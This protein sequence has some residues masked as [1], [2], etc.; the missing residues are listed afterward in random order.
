MV[1]MLMLVFGSLYAQGVPRMVAQELLDFGGVKFDPD[2]DNI[3]DFTYRTWIAERPEYI[4]YCPGPIG[5]VTKEYTP[6]GR[7]VLGIQ[8]ANF[9]SLGAPK[10][11][12]N[13]ETVVIEATQVSTGRMAHTSFV[14]EGK[15]TI[16]RYE[17]YG[18]A[19][20][21]K[22]PPV[23]LFDSKDDAIE[24]TDANLVDGYPQ[25]GL[26]RADDWKRYGYWQA[27]FST[28]GVID[29]LR[30]KSRVRSFYD[31]DEE[32]ITG[33]RGYRV[34]YSI[35]NG[36]NWVQGVDGNFLLNSTN[37]VNIDFEL[38]KEC[39]NFDKVLVKWENY[40]SLLGDGWGEIGDV[41]V[42]GIKTEDQKPE[43][44]MTYDGTNYDIDYNGVQLGFNPVAGQPET[45]IIVDYST[46]PTT[47][48]VQMFPNP[49]ALGAYIIFEFEDPGVLAAGGEITLQFPN[50]P[51]QIWYRLDAAWAPIPWSLVVGPASP[52]YTY[53]I[54]LT[55]LFGRENR[56]GGTIEFA[57]DNGLGTLPVELA[58]FTA[59]VTANMFVELQW[60][61]ETETNMLGYNVYR[62][63]VN[64]INEAVQVTPS[65]IPA[66]NVSE[67][68]KYNFV[69]EDVEAGFT[70]YYWLQ[71]VDLDLTSSFHGPVAITVEEGAELPEPTF[72]TE[73]RRNFPNPFNPET[74]IQF[75]LR[76]DVDK[77]ELKVYNVLG[78]VVRT[79]AAGPHAK[80]D[81][82][83]VW[84]GKTDS[85]KSAT[86]GIYFYQ[87]NT[88]N[89]SKIHKMMLLK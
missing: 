38:P 46:D 4:L 30:V 59:N 89:Y 9:T 74:T 19:M 22:D 17:E 66:H 16:V 82:K 23:A 40:L 64:S 51:G 18:T 80:G 81:Y 76:E 56:A 20:A 84:D 52:D 60:V 31:E 85:G 67:T 63:E 1:L 8:I 87:M 86:S 72:A 11:W 26:Y 10:D 43:E 61:S 27:S 78:Q 71:N 32:S 29:E 70:F 79:L 15:E 5:G 57:G 21:L 68:T 28:K 35:D 77:M 3:E 48:S 47:P 69:D 36:E 44:Q 75:S 2:V 6:E 33:P 12:S 65:I 53:A 14:L 50:I 13:G 41:T 39:Y 45:V 34:Y 58:S 7:L 42:T 83:V 54:D 55:A 25:E 62:S 37:W 88:P 49:D 73:L 24:V